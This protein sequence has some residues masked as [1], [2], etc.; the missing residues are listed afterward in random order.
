MTP[1]RW[2]ADGPAPKAGIFDPMNL[3]RLASAVVLT[4]AVSLTAGCGGSEVDP[5]TGALGSTVEP[6]PTTAAPT[7]TPLPSQTPTPTT[8]STSAAP[9]SSTPTARG[10]DGDAS[11]G[12][13]PSTAGGGVC[14]HLGASQVG[15]ILGVGV[16][17]A[18][19]PGETGCT[20]EQGGKRGMTVTVLDKSTAQAGGMAGAKDEANSAVE[21]TPQDLPGIGSAA[22]VVTGAMFGGPD[23]N[24]AGAVQVGSRI[25]SVYLV[26]RAGLDDATVRAHEVDL[27]KLVATAR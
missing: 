9:A 17:G 3:T 2:L 8:S 18:A 24:G 4:G 22:F 16:A 14:S 25:I 7:P 20:F 15:A 26:Q 10:G 13:S 27:L 1:G 23:V 19:V 6:T 12:K 21:G 5:G 11:G